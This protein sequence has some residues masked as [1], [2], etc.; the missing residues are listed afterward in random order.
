MKADVGQ[1][2][3]TKDNKIFQVIY[4]NEKIDVIADI[5]GGSCRFDEIVKVAKTPKEL[6]LVGDLVSNTADDVL[7]YVETEQRIKS[8][9]K[10]W[11]VKRILT[12]NSNNGYDLQ[13]IKE[14]EQ[15]NIE[16]IK[17]VIKV[18][19]DLSKQ[20]NKKENILDTGRYNYQP[21]IYT[22]V[23]SN[24]FYCLNKYELLLKEMENN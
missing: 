5:Q 11:L 19:E 17:L 23:L 22:K 1:W 3:R 20:I 16:L 12:P 10:Y 4:V 14:T 24:V 18:T 21:K 13:Y 2:V 8:I 7:E 15:T 6:I 9:S